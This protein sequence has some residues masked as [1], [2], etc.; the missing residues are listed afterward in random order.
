VNR[1]QLGTGEKDKEDIARQ[2]WCTPL[3]LALERHRIF[4][5]EASL[6]YRVSSRT[7]RAEKPCLEKQNKTKKYENKKLVPGCSLSFATFWV[8][9]FFHSFPSFQPHNIR[10]EREKDGGKG[11]RSLNK[12]RVGKEVTLLLDYFLL[13]R[14]IKFLGSS[15]ILRISNFLL[16][17]LRPL[18]PPPSSSGFVFVDEYLKK[19]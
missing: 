14:D 18:L 19:N 5:F 8:F 6:V 15:L 2:W 10:G 7:V 13:M 3:I 16:S 12:G 4:E 1:T 11:K 9:S 17:L